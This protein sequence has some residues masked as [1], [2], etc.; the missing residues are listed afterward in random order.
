V[1]D[2]LPGDGFEYLNRV[3]SVGAFLLGASTLP[4]L[5]NVWRTRRH[6][7]VVG[8][9]PWDGG[10]TLEWWTSS[11]PP[12]ENFDGPLPPITSNRPVWDANHPADATATR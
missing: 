9:D 8:P 5:W 6:G 4:F 12:P 7:E 11:P 1:A 3:S 10:Q 2:Y